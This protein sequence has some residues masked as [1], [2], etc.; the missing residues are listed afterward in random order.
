MF[1]HGSYLFCYNNERED[2]MSANQGIACSL[3]LKHDWNFSRLFE[4]W[5]LGNKYGALSSARP[6]MSHKNANA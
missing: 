6:S 5:Q 2:E 1:S 4:G 3:L